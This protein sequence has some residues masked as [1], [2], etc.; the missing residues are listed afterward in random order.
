MAG[1]LALVTLLFPSGLRHLPGENKQLI[2]EALVSAQGGAL[3]HIQNQ[4]GTTVWDN[5]EADTPSTL[6]SVVLRALEAVWFWT[7]L[8]RTSFCL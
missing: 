6:E 5:R 8:L 3:T 2:G 1:L 7:P 4:K